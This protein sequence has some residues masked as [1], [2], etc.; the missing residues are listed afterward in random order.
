[1]RPKPVWT[2]SEIHSP[3]A[4]HVLVDLRQI[5]RRHLDH[6]TDALG[7]LGDE[8]GDL[9]RGAVLNQVEDLACVF[10]AGLRI[11]V[12]VGAAI[13]IGQHRMLHA[14]IVWRV[15]F[16]V[17]VAGQRHGALRATVIAVAQ[18]DDIEIAGVGAR[19]Q[20]RHVIG[21]AAGIDEVDDV[22][23]T[24]L[25]KGVGELLA[26]LGNVRVQIDR[27]GVLQ[28]LVLLA[29]R[30]DHARMAMANAD[31][32]DAGERVQIALALLVEQI[33]HRTLH[34]HQRIPVH[35][36]QGR[37]QILASQRQHLVLAGTGVGRRRDRVGGKV[38]TIG[39]SGM[40]L[41]VGCEIG[42]RRAPAEGAD[43]S[44]S[45]DGRPTA[46]PRWRPTSSAIVVESPRAQFGIQ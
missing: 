13:A 40:G 22:Q 45:A 42:K 29:H 44:A 30:R 15:E 21:F 31:R 28:Q 32:D 10:A 12:A 9:A 41:L 46:L 27:S 5:A 37:R 43:C 6:A 17:A 16:P 14:D 20:H 23:A 25:G 24:T 18:R 8:G 38:G 34:D 35:G 4:A 3:P 26:E 19:H 36:D 33:L 1:M 7:R 11:V 2:S 39:A